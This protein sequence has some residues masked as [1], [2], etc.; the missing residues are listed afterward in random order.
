MTDLHSR[1]EED[2]PDEDDDH[3]DDASDDRKDEDEDY[4]ILL[5]FLALHLSFDMFAFESNFQAGVCS[6]QL[7]VCRRPSSDVKKTPYN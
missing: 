6:D 3:D 2:D 1:K 5:G 7:S 4:A